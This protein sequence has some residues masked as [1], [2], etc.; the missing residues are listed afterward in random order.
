M[1]EELIFQLYW[2]LLEPNMTLLE[3]DTL[4]CA[5]VDSIRRLYDTGLLGGDNVSVIDYALSVFQYRRLD[6]VDSYIIAR[7]ILQQEPFATFDVAMMRTR[8]LLQQN[9]GR[10]PVISSYTLPLVDLPS[11]VFITAADQKNFRRA[12]LLQLDKMQ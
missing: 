6:W 12:G 9:G 8:S 11:Y 2:S 7:C 3:K 10:I 5:A 1:L 4:R